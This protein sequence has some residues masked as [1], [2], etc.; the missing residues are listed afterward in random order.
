VCVCVCVC[1]C[2]RVCVTTHRELR[3]MHKCDTETCTVAGAGAT[4]QHI[5]DPSSSGQWPGGLEDSTPRD[6]THLGH[7]AAGGNVNAAQQASGGTAQERKLT[8]VTYTAT[9]TGRCSLLH[10]TARSGTNGVQM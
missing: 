5:G 6:D 2:V 4:A 10:G 3:P 1:V 8:H 7:G 9:D